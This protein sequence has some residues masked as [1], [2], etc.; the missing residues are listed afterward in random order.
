MSPSEASW[1]ADGDTWPSAAPQPDLGADRA[2]PAMTLRELAQ[3]R[4]LLSSLLIASTALFA[5]GVAAERKAV[6][7]RGETSVESVQTTELGRAAESSSERATG[8]E[9]PATEQIG[10][11][12]TSNE[13]VLGVNLESTA[14]VI[15]AAIAAVALALLTWRLD[16]RCLLLATVAFAATFAAFDIAELAHQIKESR[17]SIA[18][19]AALIAL[20]HITTALLAQQRATRTVA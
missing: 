3:P 19:L 1:S 16:P 4:W 5:A 18:A 14:L 15:V 20:L 7:R 12:E 10:H 2:G 11:T 13:T 9:Q 8:S 6:Q 17:A